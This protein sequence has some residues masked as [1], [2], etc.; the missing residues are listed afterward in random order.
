MDDLKQDPSSVGELARELEKIGEKAFR[1]KYSHPF[2]VEVYRPQDDFEDDDDAQTGEVPVVDFSQEVSKW[3]IMKA[4]A[5][6]KP[7]R[8]V[9]E[10]RVTVGRSKSNNIV[11]R[12]S[13][14][15]K[16]H[17]AFY[18]DNEHWQLM[19]LGSVNGTAV[20]GNRL[21]NNQKARIKSKDVI[22]FWR[23]TFEFHE[24]SS[25]IKFLL[26]VVLRKGLRPR[27][28]KD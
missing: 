1:Q 15:S 13:K 21:Q 18:R 17:A 22:S 5:V 26:M 24:A 27:K 8:D 20:N 7:N 4:I 19:D 3:M 11:L 9:S 14:I 10:F 28:G 25:F 16:C 23:Y 12:G 6:A 2:L